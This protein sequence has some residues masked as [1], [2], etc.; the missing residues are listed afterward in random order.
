MP[1]HFIQPHD[2][3]FRAEQIRDGDY[4]ELSNGHAIQCMSTGGRGSKKTTFGVQILE[5]DPDVESAGVDTGFSPVPNM[6]RAPDIAVG[7]IPDQPGWVQGVPALAVEYA[8]TGQ[9]EESLMK[10]I[11]EFFTH[12]TKYIWVVRLIGMRRVEVYE[13]GKPMRRV[14]S[15][16]MLTAPGVLRNP[17][18]VDALYDRDAAHEATLRNLL[19]RQGYSSLDQVKSEGK[20]EGKA[21]GKIQ[22]KAAAILAV[23]ASRGL[24][25]TAQE[26]L[27]ILGCISDEILQGWLMRVS[28]ISATAELFE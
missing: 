16:E 1:Q 12:G 28:H 6:L 17:V 25:I 4:Y 2:G 14:L 18:L 10:K 26:R 8:D 15:G 23:L 7:N 11:Q 27:Q 3:P 5:T 21:E 19:Q 20:A 13:P 22:G 24:T 9:D